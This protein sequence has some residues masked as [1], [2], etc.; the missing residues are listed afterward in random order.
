MPELS[1]IALVCDADHLA[2][3][4]A[5]LIDAATATQPFGIRRWTL[6]SI[7]R[8]FPPLRSTTCQ[9]SH[10]LFG[11]D[12]LEI[13]GVGGSDASME[14][15]TLLR[16]HCDAVVLFAGPNAAGRNGIS[17]VIRRVADEQPQTAFVVVALCEDSL[18][19]IRQLAHLRHFRIPG[20]GEVLSVTSTRQ[21]HLAPYQWQ[22]AEVLKDLQ[23]ERIDQPTIG[24]G[25]LLVSRR[26][27]RF[28]LSRRTWQNGLDTLGTFGGPLQRNG[29]VADT[30][31]AYGQQRFHLPSRLITPGPLLA[32]TNMREATGHYVD[33][34]FLF[35]TSESIPS[36]VHGTS[37]AS[38]EEMQSHL[39]HDRLYPP[40]AN[41]FLR[42]C[43]LEAFGRLSRAVL[44]PPT[45]SWIQPNFTEPASLPT[46]RLLEIAALLGSQ[47]PPRE[48]W[49]LFFEHG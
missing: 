25:A 13:T 26:D 47:S 39:E 10:F 11:A 21:G 29:S 37:W 16:R 28:F 24:V 6:C 3:E 35:T 49:P 14:L 44:A 42:Y 4:Q 19:V 2:L 32:C 40:V 22:F 17:E 31:L 38:I 1:L 46:D 33:M 34:T 20:E 41:A 9:V 8:Q 30:I 45:L 23:Q 7:V 43:A 12:E 48:M 18:E 5:G 15:D 36:P 27:G